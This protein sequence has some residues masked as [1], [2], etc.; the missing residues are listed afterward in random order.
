MEIVVEEDGDEDEAG[1]T[2]AVGDGVEGVKCLFLRLTDA[3]LAV[4]RRVRSF[5][6][7]SIKAHG[8]RMVAQLSYKDGQIIYQASGIQSR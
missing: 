5:F 2:V 7:A 3:I 1:E 8:G 4:E 6:E